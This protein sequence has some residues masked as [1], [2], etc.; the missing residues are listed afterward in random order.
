MKKSNN[1]ATTNNDALVDSKVKKIND[2]W[3]VEYILDYKG[4]RIHI[5]G[6]GET[7]DEALKEANKKLTPYLDKEVDNDGKR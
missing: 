7:T 1:K 5:K 3:C 4:K 6:Y 2:N